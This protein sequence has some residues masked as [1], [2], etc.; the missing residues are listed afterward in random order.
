MSC[1][2]IAIVGG[3]C[4]L[5]GA[6]SLSDLADLLFC[7][8]DAVTEIPDGRWSKSFYSDPDRH[9]PGKSYTFAAGC[10][11]SIDE[12]D[13]GFFGMSPRE[14]MHT[15]PQQRLLLELA[16]EAF[17]DA[18]WRPSHLSGRQAAVYVGASGWDY[19]TVKVGDIALMD[20]HSMQGLSLSSLANRISYVFNLAGPSLTVDTACSSALVAVSLG[21]DALRRGDVEIAVVGAVNLL[22]SPQNFVGFSRAS[23]LSPTGRCHAFDARADGYVRGEGGG[24]VL[25]KPLAKAIADG[26]QIR[27]VIRGAGVNSDGRTPGF[28]VPGEQAQTELLRRIYAASGVDPNDLCYLEAHGTGTPVGDPIEAAAL[29]AALA[30]QREAPLPIGSVKSNIGHLEAASGMAGLMKLLAILEQGEIPASLHCETPNPKI[31]FKELNLSVVTRRRPLTAGPRGVLLGVNSFGFGGT[32]AHVILSGP[33]ARADFSVDGPE[34]PLAISAKSEQAL[35]ALARS[36][37]ARLRNES[38]AGAQSL[39]RTAARARDH[40][41]HRL[42]SPAA[43]PRAMAEDLESW[44]AGRQTRGFAGR[45]VEGSVAFVYAGNGSQWSGMGVE[46]YAQNAAFRAAVAEVDENFAPKAGWSL[47]QALR[48]PPTEA[49]LQRAQIAQPL[50]FAVQVGVTEA[51]RREGLQPG[52]VVGHSVGEV[53]A[54]WAS[55]ALSLADATEVIIH[56]SVLQQG[57]H[58]CGGMAVLNLSAEAA[59]VLIDAVAPAVEVAAI[60]SPHTVT[61]AGATDDLERLAAA[62]HA[63]RHAFLPL[64]L[65]YAFHSRAMDPLEGPLKVSL[66]SLRPVGPAIP[67]A[68]TTTGGLVG[69]GELDGDYWWRNVR[70]PVLFSTALGGLI[71]QGARLFVEIGPKPALRSHIEAMLKQ[72]DA[73]GA[74]LPSLTSAPLGADPIFPVAARAHVAGA[75]ITGSARF[76]GPSQPRR[77]PAYPWQRQQHW[78][79]STSEA[80][81]FLA[82]VEDHPLLG[83][84]RDVDKKTWTNLLS[85]ARFPWLADHRVDG[86]PVLPAAAMIDVALAACRVRQGDGGA[87]EIEDFEVLSPLLVE[88]VRDT[89]FEVVAPGRFELASRPRLS[90]EERVVFARGTFAPPPGPRPHFRRAESSAGRGLDTE[91]FYERISGLGV[92]YGPEFRAVETARVLGPDEVEVRFPVARSDI[93]AGWGLDPRLLDATLQALFATRSLDHTLPGDSIMP[94]RFGRI[95]HLRPEAEPVLGACRLKRIGPKAHCADFALFDAD[96]EVVAELLD[97][98]FVRVRP[99]QA[100]APERLFWSP[101]VACA[102]QPAARRLPL[103]QP[104]AAEPAL[105]P[106]ASE[107]LAHAYASAVAYETLQQFA[108]EGRLAPT[109]MRRDGRLAADSA[110]ALETLLGWLQQDG[111]VAEA[112]G[113]WSLAPTS[114]LPAAAE[115]WQTLFFDE[116]TASAEL[117]LAATH[118]AALPA[119]LSAAEVDQ[120]PLL[121]PVLEASPTALAAGEALER[122]LRD[123]FAAWPDEHPIRIAIIGRP[124]SRF[125]RTL[126]AMTSGTPRRLFIFSAER[127]S[128]SLAA[129]MRQRPG[130]VLE[131]GPLTED[132]R[133]CFDIIISAFGLSEES[134]MPARVSAALD[135][136]G[137]LLGVEAQPSRIWS[138]MNGLAPPS[139]LEM[140]AEQLTLAGLNGLSWT[141]LAST[142]WGSAL[143]TGCASLEHPSVGRTESFT[144]VT[145]GPSEL[146][147]SIAEISGAPCRPLKSLPTMPLGPNYRIVAVAPSSPDIDELAAFCGSLAET[148]ALL[149]ATHTSLTLVIQSAD[150]DPT[151]EALSGLRRVM[152]NEGLDVRLIHA[153]P[154]V[155]ASQVLAEIL[156]VDENGDVRLGDGTRNM[157]QVRLG[158][159]KPAFAASARR[160]EITRPGLLTSLQWE[161]FEPRSPADGEV[162][163]AVEA[164]G[165]NFRDVMWALGALPDEALMDGFSGPTLGL[166]CAGVVTAVGSGVT[167]IR[168]GDHVAALAPNALATDVVTTASA[169]LPLPKDMDFAAG[170]TLPVTAMTVIY[171]LGRLAQLAPGER[172]L[173][174][175]ALGGVG[176]LAIQYARARGAEIYATAGSTGRRAVLRALGVEHV[177]DSRSVTFADAILEATQGE[178]VDV[179]LNSLSGELMHQSLRLLRPFGRFVE[180]GKRDLYANS[181]IGLRPLRHNVSYFAVDADQLPQLRGNIAAEVMGEAARLIASGELRPLP[182]RCYAGADVL[183]A[184]RL[185]QGSSHIGKIVVRPA[186][187]ARADNISPPPFAARADRTYIVTGG[188]AGFGL[189]TARWL[190]DHGAGALALLSRQGPATPGIDAALSAFAQQG[191]NARAYAC[192]VADEA[193]LLATL[194]E[195]RAGQPPIAGVVHAA[196]V[197]D[198]GLLKDLDAGRFRTSLK[199]KLA[200]AL[201]LDRLTRQDPIEMFVLYSSISAAVG[202]PGQG[203]YVVANAALDA[204]ARRRAVEGLPALSVQWGPIS[205]TGILSRDGRVRELLERVLASDELT[206][207]SALNALPLLLNSGSPVAGYAHVN[208]SV[209]KRQ[210]R[211]GETPMLSEVAETN[212]TRDQDLTL[213]DQIVKL[214]PAA[215]RSLIETFLADEVSAIM[216]LSRAA[217]QVDEPISQMGFDSLMT[218]ELHLAVESRLQCEIPVTAV[219]SAA[220]LRSIATRLVQRLQGEPV[221]EEPHDDIEHQLMRHE[222]LEVGAALEAAE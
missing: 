3:A 142:V 154:D 188:A 116:P 209:L 132:H 135:S 88:G 176:L 205:D 207:R 160:L 87:V 195:I 35:E 202:N 178:G 189:E 112:A 158:Q 210:L 149:T 62:A 10:L 24:V 75:D 120:R 127:L 182:H 61:V 79:G 50:L 109:A 8:R 38:D 97:C 208:W 85:I 69:P 32:N 131:S 128:Q 199:P 105:E 18:G 113:A 171:A 216:R 73:A 16:Y 89:R 203:N 172:V 36:W 211:L 141:P 146:A 119:K 47:A 96:G 76:E 204:I 31:P 42:V 122:C 220:T 186:D 94:W 193:D 13:A 60:N 81:E 217:I 157:R 170:A 126:E 115:I 64:P 111:L 108:D 51:L 49:D 114:G 33:P 180:I 4:R 48:T 145:L 39:A 137:L 45:A 206:A 1:I 117:A 168:P 213:R 130:L 144:L 179:V 166:E 26:D 56:R 181:L 159:A 54:A 194:G 68:S 218:L 139:S 6:R 57:L 91:A 21:C 30:Q 80:I 2:D 129:E 29:G 212:G 198:D 67:M 161:A 197:M 162:A 12:F 70:D 151:A 95:R 86:A 133:Q 65:T 215:A 27:A 148:F 222:V 98:W 5:P 136:G 25:L 58:G 123:V 187:G 23:M 106:S 147:Q 164:S 190:A 15:D 19:A 219:S 71:E 138:L 173:I 11:D 63:A 93:G 100:A 77:L 169:V 66:A 140:L 14:A 53:A 104:E 201:A 37:A 143:L 125:C 185:M 150:H 221:E 74:V 163:I 152:L 28:S 200:G 17:E 102:V 214:D 22:I 155:S 72:H 124:T 55:G 183:D 101:A 46:A 103:H 107:L 34:P 92:E 99:G 41:T 174:H 177:Y 110:Q 59:R 192:D 20:T 84:R 134:L 90:T 167:G 165:L 7:E 43:A 9:Q 121:G 82:P 191:V 118:A 156:T 196:C 184:F 44:S 78:L 83:F 52:A 175:G 40:F 153:A